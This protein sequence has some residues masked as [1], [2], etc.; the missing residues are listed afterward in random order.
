MPETVIR[1]TN[2]PSF[3]SVFLQTS[4]PSI[5]R[6]LFRSSEGFESRI[7]VIEPLPSFCKMSKTT[8]AALS[9]S[10]GGNNFIFLRGL[11]TDCRYLRRQNPEIQDMFLLRC[12]VLQ[13]LTEEEIFSCLQRRFFEQLRQILFQP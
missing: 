9:C 7:K 1:F 3:A 8:P 4:T 6:E 12:P 11:Q 5:T 10:N 2:S 13:K